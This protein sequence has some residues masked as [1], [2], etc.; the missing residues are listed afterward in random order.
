MSKLFGIVNALEVHIHEDAKEA[1]R[2]GC[3]YRPPVFKPIT[4]E[5]AVIVNKGTDSGAPTVDLILRDETGQKFVVMLTG[6]LLKSLT[7]EMP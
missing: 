2:A 1:M 6:N 7:R 4:I 5:R 3:F